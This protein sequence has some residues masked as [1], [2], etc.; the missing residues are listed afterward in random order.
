MRFWRAYNDGFDDSSFDVEVTEFTVTTA[1][2]A[3]PDVDPVVP[4]MLQL[5]RDKLG[6]DLAFVN[7]TLEGVTVARHEDTAS[8]RAN[9][10]IVADRGNPSPVWR[11]KLADALP[12]C[13]ASAAG[14]RIDAPDAC[15]AAVELDNGELYGAL[16]WLD[17]HGQRRPSAR[18]MR[19][20]RY[21]AAFIADRIDR[22]RA[23]ARQQPAAA[24]AEQWRLAPVER[25]YAWR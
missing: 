5:M 22:A 11:R 6:M 20:M 3:A 13:F 14:L 25:A 10:T 1:Q 8:W 12:D 15:A 19:H 17:A 7:G 4:A 16:I 23:A 24:Q 9:T 2:C 18:D 21:V